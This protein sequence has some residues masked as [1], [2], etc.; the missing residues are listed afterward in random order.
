MKTATTFLALLFISCLS[1][2]QANLTQTLTAFSSA[3]LQAQ[4]A[5]D[6]HLTTNKHLHNIEAEINIQSAPFSLVTKKEQFSFEKKSFYNRLDGYESCD[7]YRR[8]KNIGGWTILGGGILSTVAVGM[9]LDGLN[10]EFYYN[11]NAPS[12]SEIGVYM[13]VA[14]D[15]I[16][17]VG[18]IVAAT[19]KIAYRHHRCALQLTSRGNTVGLAYPFNR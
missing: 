11:S 6:A 13:L 14:G 1:M 10:Q 5:T 18:T 3:D 2:A 17:L 8:V 16:Q 12:Q 15:I 9:I 4:T 19:G 7:R